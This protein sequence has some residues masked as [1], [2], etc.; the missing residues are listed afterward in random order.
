MSGFGQERLFREGVSFLIQYFFGTTKKK[1]RR[2]RRKTK[3]Q[4]SRLRFAARLVV[5]TGIVLFAGSIM[6]AGY[7]RLS[8]PPGT[9]L[10]VQRSLSGEAIS[11]PWK[12][13]EEMSPHLVTA[14]I[15]A[16]DTRFCFHKGIDFDAIDKALTEAEN[17]KRLRGAST[18]SQQTAK[19][20]F[21]W[22]G[23]GW[24]RKGGEAWM[25]MLIE[26]IWP[27]RRIIEVYLNIAEWGDGHFGAEAAA[28]ARF[29]KSAKDLTAHEAAL[30]ASVLPNPHKWRVDPPGPYVRSRVGTVR[31]RMNQV[32]RDGLDACV[33]NRI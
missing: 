12:P 10:M 6:W 29:G 9:L 22:N 28:Q 5:A 18:I 31:V 19:N 26:A 16:E 11:H 21:L 8:P 27:K 2:K 1:R 7:Y 32:R 24:L 25:T 3:K 14:V 15:A 30:L 13:L 33:L 23:G 4:P 20:A 17:G